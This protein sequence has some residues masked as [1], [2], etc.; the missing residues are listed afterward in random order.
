MLYIST[1][2]H[3]SSIMNTRAL[4]STLV[5][6]AF[7]LKERKKRKE[8]KNRATQQREGITN[9]RTEEKE[10]RRSRSLAD[11]LRRSELETITK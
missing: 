7:K 6:F 9:E 4:V 1:G 10:R 3:S 2:A 5:L 11:S 8:R